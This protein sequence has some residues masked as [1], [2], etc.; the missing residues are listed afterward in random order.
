[1][2][3]NPTFRHPATAGGTA[4][5]GVPVFR[6]PA[7]APAMP[8]GV[9]LSG[10]G[11]FSFVVFC[12]YAFILL[13]RPQ[14]YFPPLVPLRLALLF[15]VLTALATVLRT[16]RTSQ[17]VW[18]EPESKL[19]LAFFAAM[20]LGIP[21]ALHR[22]VTFEAV[23]Q[24]YAVNMAFYVL[25]LVHVNTMAR[26][27]RIGLVAVLSSLLLTQFALRFG[28]FREGRITL[29]NNM[30]DPNDIAFVQIALFAFMLWLVLGS[31]ARTVKSLALASALLGALITLYTGSRGGL[32]GMAALFLLFLWLRVPNLKRSFKTLMV[33]A[34]ITTGVL[35][36]EKI[37]VERYLT[38]TSLEQD[39]NFGEF[40]RMDIWQRGLALF[41]AHPLT[42]VG[43]DNFPMAIGLMRTAESRVPYWQAPHSA[44]LQVLTETGVLGM[45]AFVLLIGTSLRS[46]NRLRRQGP[47][48][49]ERDLGI[50]SGLLL[51]G[52]LAVLISAAFL[53]QAYSMF[54]TL[55]FA[56]AA[57]LKR[58]AAAQTQEGHAHA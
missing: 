20:C 10:E 46:F 18:R 55:Y 15:T 16:A 34:V 19:Y 26:L 40:G 53:S 23:L 42:G 56:A 22:R 36:A 52:F 27:R 25:F 17:S 14:D 29:N 48:A 12:V 24:Q 13:G 49:P 35:N 21:F 4:R 8:S 3:T 32:I 9:E 28:E 50:L 51:I 7:P 1:M 47:A 6:R 2:M 33:A 45:A 43:V 31:S 38:L 39:A 5:A 44:Y 57:A 54:F 30:Y 11:T 37:N 41:T 58:I